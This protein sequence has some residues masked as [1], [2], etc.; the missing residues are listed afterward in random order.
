MEALGNEAR[1]PAG[2]LVEEQSLGRSFFHRQERCI[3]L[4][5]HG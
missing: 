2:S 4:T 1:V 5:N 3:I